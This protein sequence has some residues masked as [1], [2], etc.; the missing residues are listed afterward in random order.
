MTDLT[1]LR[2]YRRPLAVI[3]CGAAGSPGVGAMGCDPAE[4]G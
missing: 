2:R 1:S 3:D 4:A